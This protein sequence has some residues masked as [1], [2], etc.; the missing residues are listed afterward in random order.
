[1]P[2][3]DLE[4]MSQFWYV[5]DVSRSPRL[6]SELYPLSI[7]NTY[8]SLVLDSNIHSTQGLKVAHHAS[9]PVFSRRSSSLLCPDRDGVKIALAWGA[10]GECHPT[11]PK[12]NAVTHRG[13]QKAVAPPTT[14]KAKRSTSQHRGT[15]P[16]QNTTRDT[17]REQYRPHIAG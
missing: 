6:L 2:L 3:F 16:R 1:M 5:M 7:L 11:R 8:F 12:T 14:P 10:H 9:T 13:P 17:N 4:C 15:E